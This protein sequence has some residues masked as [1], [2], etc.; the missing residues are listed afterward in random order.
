MKN[1]LLNLEYFIAVIFIILILNK[2]QLI[3]FIKVE[4]SFQNILVIC[5]FL[6]S[7]VGIIGL[8]LEKYWGYFSIYIFIVSSLLLGVAPIPFIVN[9][10][11]P[12]SRT[13]IVILS[14]I[15]LF[16]LIL[17]LQMKRIKSL[18]ITKPT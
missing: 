10:F 9:L 1:K 18:N 15:I 13:P 12:Q 6:F 7:F 17:F 4:F 5:F 3:N 14:S 16:L 8:F 2:Y 11:P